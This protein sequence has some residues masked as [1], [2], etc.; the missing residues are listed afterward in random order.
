MILASLTLPKLEKPMVFGMRILSLPYALS[1]LQGNR[2][3]KYLFGTIS[4][5]TEASFHPFAYLAPLIP[6]TF[7]QDSRTR[8]QPVERL[9][10][11]RYRSLISPLTVRQKN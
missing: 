8:I 4:N 1:S 10:E 3:L 6:A 9:N 2:K 7:I 11:F 5:M